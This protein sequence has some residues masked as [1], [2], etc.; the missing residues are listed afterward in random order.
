MCRDVALVTQT[1]EACRKGWSLVWFKYGGTQ[2]ELDHNMSWS[3]NQIYACWQQPNSSRSQPIYG[4]FFHF[5]LV[6]RIF[7]AHYSQC[8]AYPDLEPMNGTDRL[9]QDW[10]ALLTLY[11]P[12]A[13]SLITD[14]P[15]A[16]S[17][18]NIEVAAAKMAS[19]L[20][21]FPVR[22]TREMIS[23]WQKS[24]VNRFCCCCAADSQC[25]RGPKSAEQQSE[26]RRTWDFCQWLEMIHLGSNRAHTCTILF[27]GSI[28][29]LALAPSPY[30]LSF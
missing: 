7:F 12:L 29:V 27:D 22:S 17:N 11:T 6:G 30:A 9:M 21:S 26:N 25:R 1:Y 3:L 15:R 13:V 5:G 28:S 16:F 10:A 18:N 23:H 2:E 19:T 8:N 14:V 24:Q 4:I 20:V